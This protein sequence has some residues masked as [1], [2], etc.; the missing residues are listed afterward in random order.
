[1]AERHGR[2]C[3]RVRQGAGPHCTSALTAVLPP[4][5]QRYDPA[6]RIGIVAPASLCTLLLTS[7]LTDQGCG[8][9]TV[10]SCLLAYQ[11]PLRA[12]HCYQMT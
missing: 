10:C 6:P 9:R 4:C 5:S 1:M 11:S 7:Y 2:V 8:G 12:R 3:D